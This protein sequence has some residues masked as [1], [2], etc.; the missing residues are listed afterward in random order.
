MRLKK[1][2]NY[3]IYNALHCNFCLHLGLHE[4]GV[5]P[6]KMAKNKKAPTIVSALKL[7]RKTGLKPA[8]PSLEG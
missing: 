7:E 4:G 3:C 5:K 2:A 8:T 6:V 1:H